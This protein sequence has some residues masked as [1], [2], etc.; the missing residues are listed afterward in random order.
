MFLILSCVT[1]AMVTGISALTFGGDISKPVQPREAS[2]QIKNEFTVKVPKGAKSVRMGFAVPQEDA[3]SAVRDFNV[4]ADF[5]V[6]YYRDDWGNRVGYAEL[7]A[8]PEGPI[9]IREEF[10]LTRIEIRNTVDPAKTRP[11]TDQERA[12]LFAFLHPP[13][14]GAINAQINWP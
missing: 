14:H 12:A 10:G 5:P 2:F 7:N 11:L 13:S 6:H 1:T 3:V 8:P 9:T 4:H